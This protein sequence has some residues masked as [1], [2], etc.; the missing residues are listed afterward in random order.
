MKT[1][2]LS[3]SLVLAGVQIASAADWPSYRGPGGDGRSAETG[4]QVSWPLEGPKVLWRTRL[5]NGFSG[6]A[7]QDD[8]L[9]TQYGDGSHEYVVA[10]DAGTGEEVWSA[11]TGDDRRDSQ[12]SGPRSTPAVDGGLVFSLGASGN[13][14]AVTAAEGTPVWSRD[15]V[16]DFGA[17]VPRWGVSASPVVAG[18][19]L[20][21]EAGGRRDY[22][23]V[24]L[25]KDSGELRW[26]ARSDRAGYS[27]PLV[28]EIGGR[29]QAVFFT[30]AGLTGTALE[31]GAVL[32]QFPWETSY[33]VNAAMPV[34]V[35]EGKIFISTGY[36]KG[37]ALLEIASTE[38]GF[39]VREIW[40]SRVMRNH[41][42]S[43]VLADGHLFGF[44]NATLKCVEAASGQETWA[45]RGLGKGSLLYADSHLLVLSERGVLLSIEATPDEYRETARVRLLKGKTWTMPSLADGRLFVR[46]EREMVAVSLKP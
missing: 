3:F 29:K 6:I 17:R 13:L 33:G 32:W 19:L 26:H 41:F 2:V 38:S 1:A 42:N 35:G 9:F 30:A 11:V 5:G 20:L 23:L 46:D 28:A 14:H 27:T 8:R 21:I 12:G 34:L 18:D 40:R 16:E 44:D 37:A 31:D 45:Q 43:S 22:A 36:D 7:I 39:K 4:L 15:L 24:A 10:L 25:A